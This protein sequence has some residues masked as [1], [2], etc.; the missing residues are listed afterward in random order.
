MPLFTE[1]YLIIDYGST[2]IKGALYESGPGGV[3]LRRLESLPLVEL[4][5]EA[6][7]EAAA[8]LEAGQYEYNIVRYVQSFFPEESNYI[9]NLPLDQIYVRDLNI[10]IVNQKQL[11]EVIP[12]EVEGLLPVS[13]D[14]TEVVGRAWA[15][16]EETSNV[17]S[18]AAGRN[19]IL[20]TVLP[21]KRPQAVIRMVSV[22]AVG[23]AAFIRTLP[24]EEYRDRVLGQ[25]DI[26]GLYT[27]I[28]VVQ[29]GR[30]VYTRKL[31]IGGQH[32]TDVV[33]AEM[34]QDAITA[35][36]TKLALE[37]DLS[38]HTVER[39]ESYFRMHRVTQAQLNRIIKKSRAIVDEIAAEMD[40]SVL[41]LPTEAPGEV[42]L[43]GG[44]ALMGGVRETLQEK[45]GARVREYPLELSGSEPVTLW[46]TAIGTANHYRLKQTEKFDFLESPFGNTL[47]GG[48]LSLNMFSTPILFAALAAI[49]FLASTVFDIVQDR[50]QIQ[51]YDAMIA[52][53][54]KAVID[55]T[56]KISA[57]VVRLVREQCL[58]R[59]RN[60][61]NEGD[62]RAL[63]ILRE[64]TN[65]TPARS[66]MHFRLKRLQ[67]TDKTVQVSAEV[68][69]F[70]DVGRLS[71]ALNTSRLVREV[72]V[73]SQN[74]MRDKVDVRLSLQLNSGS[75][76]GSARCQ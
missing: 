9:L 68:G 48:Q 76:G 56:G 4:E 15:S 14:D 1:K 59:A 40:R 19:T 27:I 60:M 62:L 58:S 7:P 55:P 8:G 38:P 64:L 10:P 11:D 69:S 13:L 23:L 31:P 24:E 43:S 30:L 18:F 32:F 49:V 53:E 67:Y 25:I 28:N 66:E 16:D 70:N 57:D 36:Q 50:R 5:A 52:E 61:Q 63:D 47:K 72:E 17:I 42:Y 20:Q 46:A 74:S 65:N 6:L 51:Q 21:L 26:G 75:G 39:P 54:S 41:S 3:Q 45:L 12:F 29:D 44:G 73:I 2:Y 33:A 22:D 34:K 35:E 37:L 71:E